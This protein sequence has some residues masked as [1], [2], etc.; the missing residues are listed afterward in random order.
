[1]AGFSFHN[2]NVSSPKRLNPCGMGTPSSLFLSLAIAETSLICFVHT[3]CDLINIC[4]VAGNKPNL[5]L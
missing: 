5:H 1:M 3:V 2:K 4:T